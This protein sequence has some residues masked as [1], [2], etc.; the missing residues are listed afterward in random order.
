MM[1][2][3]FTSSIVCVILVIYIYTGSERVLVPV[4]K[5]NMSL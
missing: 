1:T 4:G 5:K 2:N 3:D